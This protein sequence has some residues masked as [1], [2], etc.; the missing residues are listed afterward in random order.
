MIA[1]GNAQLHL[2]S[3]KFECDILIILSSFY[4]FCAVH[5]IGQ[6][7]SSMWRLLFTMHTSTW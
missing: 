7:V 1:F 4:R 3:K 2:R 5:V 6:L